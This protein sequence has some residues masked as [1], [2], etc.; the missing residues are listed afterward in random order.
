MAHTESRHQAGTTLE[1]ALRIALYVCF[2]ISGIAGLG[3]EVIW[4]KYLALYVGGTGLAQVIVL[5][6]FMGGLALG[7]WIFGSF[8]DR[9]ANPLKLYAFLEFGIGVYALLFDRIFE[10]GR[11]VFIALAKTDEPQSGTLFAGKILSCVLSVL[12][13]TILMGGTMPAMA[14][15]LVRSVK[16][17]GP[18]ISRLYFL[19]SIGAV[20][21]CLAAGFYTIRVMGLQFTMVLGA[22]LNILAGLVAWVAASREAEEALPARPASRPEVARDLPLPGWVFGVLL[23]CVGV[24]G[25]ISMMY[26][27]AWIRLL[28]LVLGSSTY[29]F[30]LMLATFIFGLSLGGL[31]LSFKRRP[32]GY[33]L[34]FGL[35]SAGVGLSV[36]LA[37]PFYERL[38]YFFNLIAASL[39]REPATF[40]LYQGCQLILCA[41]VMIVPTILQGITLPAA[42]KALMSDPRSVGG[43]VGLVFAV[44]TLGTL[45]GSVFA[46]FIGL[47]WLGLK[48][49]LELAIALNSV[50]GLL[51]L[52][53][54]RPG[55]SRTISIVCATLALATVWTWYVTAIRHWDQNVLA[56][57]AYRERNRMPSFASFIDGTTAH[58]QL[59][60]RDGID[61]TVAV[62]ETPDTGERYLAINGKVDASLIGDLPT[63]KI[64]GHLPLLLH[65]GPKRV[66]VIGIGSGATIGAVLAHDNVERVDVVEISRDVVDASRYF[67]AVNAR[68]W[69]DPRVHVYIE[70]AKTFFQVTDRMYDVI[71]SEPSNPWIAGVAGVFSREYFEIC[72][73]HLAPAG[74]FLQWTH[75]YELENAAF[76]MILE[77]FTGVFPCYSLWNAQS[78][79][80]MILGAVGP[81]TPD[82]ARME[83]RIRKPAVNG[84]LQRIGIRTL[85][86][87]LAIQ[88]RNSAGRPSHVK[89]TGAIHSDFFPVLEYIAPRGFFIGGV[90]SGVKWLD[91]R[92]QSRARSRL[93]I[94]D[95]LKTYE[96]SRDELRDLFTYIQRNGSMF[97][98]CGFTW[99]SE[100]LAR[101]PGDPEARAACS[102]LIGMTFGVS[103]GFIPQDDA[104]IAALDYSVQKLRCSGLYADYLMGRSYLRDTTAADTL[105][106]MVWV[107]D[108]FPDHVDGDMLHWRGQ[109]QYDLG[110]YDDAVTSLHAAIAAL[111]GQPHSRGRQIEC[112]VLL[113]RALLAQGAT[114]RA[115]DA[116]IELLQPFEGGNIDVSLMRALIRD[117]GLL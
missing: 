2:F 22:V 82:F 114:Q 39:I 83:E 115:Q 43:R 45:A 4:S 77:T 21:G 80:T 14:R 1:P 5:A 111:K 110:L 66:L 65:P 58:R 55:R 109:L 87:V 88:L 19:N 16:T 48:G 57:G 62:M 38:P 94:T 44:N 95:Y 76:F 23:T 59:F 10:L 3:Y 102:T 41:T 89:W 85:L 63:Q 117:G 35:S 56:L 6:T 26:E 91:E 11:V 60:Y 61:A 84:D 108:R 92:S 30:S 64:L 12:L 106:A 107:S 103:V 74:L 113:C 28:A 9:V 79:D 104:A 7:S 112:G 31:L 116:F 36:L 53:A 52:A 32:E 13:P 68:Y 73:D 90:A 72:R 37:L 27:V 50:L 25:G 33:T 71:V 93:W 105:A 40:P 29:A 99:A 51:S 69:E 17:A 20:V 75:S 18:T 49:T 98:R 70:D 54:V 15:C 67:E 42:T 8:A 24:S 101:Y 86:P 47:P 100:W 78:T 97:D 96:P 34:V 81:Y 46:G